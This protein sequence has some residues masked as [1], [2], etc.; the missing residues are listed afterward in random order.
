LRAKVIHIL[1]KAE[2]PYFVHSFIDED[3]SRF[4]VTMYDFLAYQLGESAEE[5]P[6]YLKYFF[7]FELLAF[8]EFFEVSVF[9]ELSDDVETIFRA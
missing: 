4:E 8:H 9:T 2:I 7:L 5:L 6:H 1:G 3:V